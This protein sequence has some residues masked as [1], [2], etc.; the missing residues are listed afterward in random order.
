MLPATVSVGCS[1]AAATRP[2]TTPKA[3][4][5]ASSETVWLLA[6]VKGD[7]SDGTVVEI[8]EQHVRLPRPKHDKD[9]RISQTD[10]RR[11]SSK[12]LTDAEHEMSCL[13]VHHH[14]GPSQGQAILL[15]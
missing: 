4:G 8:C 7:E 15:V 9:M 5:Q 11:R 14:G 2:G 1:S 3:S 12:A 13:L 6:A 10:N